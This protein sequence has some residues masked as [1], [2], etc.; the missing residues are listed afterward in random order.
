[1]ISTQWRNLLIKV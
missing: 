1:M